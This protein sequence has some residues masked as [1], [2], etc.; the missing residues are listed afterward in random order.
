MNLYVNSKLSVSN[1]K[2]GLQCQFS[3][4]ISRGA[5]ECYGFGKGQYLSIE[6]KPLSI[7]GECHISCL[8]ILTKEVTNRVCIVTSKKSFLHLQ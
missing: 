6:T 1:P 3:E 8:V 5:P 7:K 4:T 2:I